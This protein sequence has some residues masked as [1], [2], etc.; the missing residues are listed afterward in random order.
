MTT[1]DGRSPRA[2]A[3]WGLALCLATGCAQA[4]KRF[5]NVPVNVF[6]IG[7]TV[8]AGHPTNLIA[9]LENTQEQDQEIFITSYYFPDPGMPSAS[10]DDVWQTNTNPNGPHRISGHMKAWRRS[11]SV[12][13]GFQGIMLIEACTRE[14][15]GTCPTNQAK[16][17]ATVIM[18]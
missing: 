16:Y 11:V 4:K 10:S 15:N 1:S 6:V 3:I 12:N 2:L 14:I 8:A 7:D 9:V 18:P 13:A 5:A 17:T